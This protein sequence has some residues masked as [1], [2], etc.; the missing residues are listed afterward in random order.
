MATEGNIEETLNDDK[1]LRQ[2]KPI[3][4]G[5]WGWVI[6][7]ASGFVFMTVFSFEKCISLFYQQLL[8]R[9][10]GTASATAAVMSLSSLFRSFGS[11]YFLPI[12][13]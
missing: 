12:I 6:V 10:G 8:F 5:G 4:D 2:T 13:I 1:K 3:P 7:L 11:K 9:F